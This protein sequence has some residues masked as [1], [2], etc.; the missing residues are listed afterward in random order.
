MILVRKLEAALRL[1]GFFIVTL[2]GL[3]GYLLCLLLGYR[4]RHFFT[5]HWWARGSC[6]AYGLDCRLT[7]KISAHKPT[8]FVSNH[9][10]YLDIV[11]IGSVVEVSF[12]AKAEMERW[13]FFGN[14]S[15]FAD[16]IF[17]SR[18]PRDAKQ[19]LVQISERLG[20][21][22]NLILFPEG[23][24]WDGSEIKPFKSS[25]FASVEDAELRD[26]LYVQPLSIAYVT[27]RNPE[28]RAPTPFA[29][30]KGYPLWKHIR[31]TAARGG[32][33][34][35]IVAYEPVAVRDF[36]DRKA[37]TDYCFDVIEQGY[38]KSIARP[39]RKYDRAADPTLR[40]SAPSAAADQ[41]LSR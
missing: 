29:W 32:A 35:R 16:T 28:E 4:A 24:S 38:F 15:K 8:L 3:I 31:E 18:N 13:P 22:R 20:E 12:A 6:L 40:R 5:K 26:K 27:K 30:C 11:A 17:I 14:L 2:S 33:E 9:L 21:D 39:V 23:T 37:L 1:G 10:S 19:A 25:P 41:N 36:A 7:G 34:V